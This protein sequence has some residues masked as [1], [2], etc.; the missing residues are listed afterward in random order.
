[1][2]A[3]T[4]WTIAAVREALQ[5]RKISARELTKEFYARIGRLNPELNAF[6]ALS[7]ERAYA[8]A[9]R[10]DATVAQG[11]PLPALAGVPAAVKDVLS[12][13]GVRTTCGSKILENYVPA[14]D[15][16]AIERL[17]QAGMQSSALPAPA[18]ANATASQQRPS[19]VPNDGSARQNP[20]AA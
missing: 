2:S 14:Y 8:A 7:P 10:V 18:P 15:A 12:T 16:T 13:R 3:A 4:P 19:P 17:E 1:M 6:L 5:T 9:D 11:T 20:C